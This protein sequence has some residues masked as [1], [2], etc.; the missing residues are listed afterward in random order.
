MSI[1]II[2]G[3]KI[4]DYINGIFI[5][6]KSLIRTF[7]VCDFLDIA[8]VAILIYHLTK[9]IRESRAGQLVKGII[10]IL[11]GYFMAS[12][13]N[14]RM[15][16][17]I[18]NNFFQFSIFGLLIVFQPELRRILEQLGRSNWSL[19]NIKRDED[20][21]TKTYKK[22]I[23]VVTQSVLS[24]SD[25][26][27][28][29]LIVFERK[30]KLGDIIDTGTVIKSVASVPLICNI[31]YNKAPLHDGALIIKDEMIYAGGC[32]LPLTKSNRLSKDLG[33]RHR[34]A[35][36]ISENSDAVAVVVSE[37]TGKVSIALNGNLKSYDS[38][39][40]FKEDLSGILLG[41]V[42]KDGSNPI[43]TSFR[44]VM[45]ND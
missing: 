9:I 38:I 41:Q 24:L 13:F 16:T 6:L 8:I 19:R 29:A 1:S 40:K 37:E 3:E 17:T 42:N 20:V 27:M 43:I 11:I 28:G 15:L 45:K 32:I 26:R 22:L 10:I 2:Y 25:E 30:T 44:K 39:D 31:F 36:G 18:F 23:D 7:T 12:Q 4:M 34:A 33:T 35:V 21:H 14:L 5:A